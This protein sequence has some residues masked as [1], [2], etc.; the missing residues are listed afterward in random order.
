MQNISVGV[1]HARVGSGHLFGIQKMK[2]SKKRHQSN[3]SCAPS[4]ENPEDEQLKPKK[5]KTEETSKQNLQ[6]QVLS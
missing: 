5:L 2:K 1:I 3:L 6:A 4:V